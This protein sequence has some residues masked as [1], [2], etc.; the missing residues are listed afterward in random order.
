[1][2]SKERLIFSRSKNSEMPHILIVDGFGQPAGDPVTHEVATSLRTAFPDTRVLSPLSAAE[3]LSDDTTVQLP[4]DTQTENIRK[5]IPSNAPTHIYAYSQG[6]IAVADLLARTS[7]P[8]VESVTFVGTPLDTEREQERVTRL[9]AS[10]MGGGFEY[11][12]AQLPAHIARSGLEG[13]VRF[14]PRHGDSAYVG[15][16]VDYLRSF[17]SKRTNFSNLGHVASKYAT[18]LISLG[19]EKVTDCTPKNARAFGEAIKMPFADQIQKLDWRRPR[20]GIVIE[21]AP[22]RLGSA[23]RTETIPRILRLRT[24]LGAGAL[25]HSL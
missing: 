16:T 8:Q 22:H 10:E 3:T 20:Q 2:A 6:G 12:E 13:V 14:Q 25:M 24:R 17:P 9:V 11:V 23:H 5:A 4:F 21:R 19:D 18:T 7:F 1:M 15:L